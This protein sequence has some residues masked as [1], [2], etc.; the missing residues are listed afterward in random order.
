M[1]K[2]LLLPVLFLV[3]KLQAQPGTVFKINYL[4]NKAYSAVVTIKLNGNLNF[5]GDEQTMQKLKDHGIS[6]PVTVIYTIKM[7]GDDRTGTPDANAVFPLVMAWQT[8]D[9]SENINGNERSLPQ[10]KKTFTIYNHI[11]PDGKIIADSV[12]GE[13]IEDKSKAALSRMDNAFQNQVKFPNKPLKVSDTFTRDLSIQILLGANNIPATAKTTYTLTSIAGGYAYF[14]MAQNI[15]AA[16]PDERGAAKVTG[17][18]TGKVV[19]SMNDGLIT[20]FDDHLNL[21]FGGFLNN[22]KVNGTG[23]METKYSYM[24]K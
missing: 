2:L 12:V 6:G 10:L 24:A 7:T 5:S 17:T 23:A 22:I 18:G 11:M 13:K 3:F 20:D 15:Y 1:K 14:D 19:Y 8:S 4:P 21:I 16:S 9:I